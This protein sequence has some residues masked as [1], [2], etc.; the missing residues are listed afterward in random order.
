MDSLI[1]ELQIIFHFQLFLSANVRHKDD[2]KG[3]RSLVVLMFQR[4]FLTWLHLHLGK[5]KISRSSKAFT[6]KID[7]TKV[8]T[9]INND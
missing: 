7:S 3:R 4:Q 5:H 2:T 6:H 8:P 9:I 1:F